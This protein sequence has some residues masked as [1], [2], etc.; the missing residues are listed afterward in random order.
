MAPCCRGSTVSCRSAGF[1][2]SGVQI[3][4]ARLGEL[5]RDPLDLGGD[6]VERAAQPQVV[7]QLRRGAGLAQPARC[8]R[9]AVRR[10]GL[11]AHEPGRPRRRRPRSRAGRQPPRA[12]ARAR[13]SAA[14]C[15]PRRA[16]SSSG[17]LAGHLQVRVER[18][19]ARLD[20][21][22]RAR[23]GARACAPRR[24]GPDTST[25]D[26]STSASSDGAPEL[27]SSTSASTCS[28]M[29]CLDVGAQLVERV[30]LAG[31]AR[32]LVV[33]LRQHLLLDLLH[34][35][36]DRHGLLRSPASSRVD[37]LRLARAHPDERL[38]RSRRTG[39]A[40]RARRR[41]PLAAVVG[42]RG[43]RRP[44]RPA[45]PD[46]RPR[47]ATSSATVERSTFSSW[48]TR[49]S[50]TRLGVRDLELL[51]VGELRLRLH[52]RTWR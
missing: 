26:A 18:D 44:C 33:E 30:E 34:D 28:R 12:R 43:R 19:A 32:E 37:L 20:L 16:T 5:G 51:P 25:F 7:A 9:V 24:A 22:A 15:S 45:G 38:P 35:G 11:L 48:S 42:D 49:S 17:V 46:G 2:F 3:C 23:A 21:T 13:P 50:G 4:F 31:R 36:L 8:I 10:S 39:A 6:A 29:R 47:P 27:A 41:S 40:S 52:R 1:S 14:A